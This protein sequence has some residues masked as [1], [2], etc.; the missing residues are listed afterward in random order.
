MSH[1]HHNLDPNIF[2]IGPFPVRWY[3]LF[4]VISFLIGYLLVKKNFKAKNIQLSGDDYDTLLFDLMLGVILGGRLG[5]ILFYN[6]AFYM[7]HPLS[8]FAVWEGGMSF[9][10]GA[11]GVIIAGL[12]FC[13]QHKITFYKLADPVMPLVAIGLGLGRIGNFINGEL[14][15]KETTVP[16]GMVFPNS[17]PLA[18]VRHPSQIYEALLEGLVLFLVCQF[19]HRKNH[20][21]GIVFWTFIGLYGI[22]RF[23]LEFLR[24]PDHIDLYKNGL[25]LGYFS[26]GQFLSLF[27]ILTSLIFII[28]IMFFGNKNEIRS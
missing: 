12:I 18:L 1:Y 22:F 28:K 6:L 8:V 26:M 19:I 2:T 4:Y 13:K 23:F 25:I 27:M 3:G 10:G 24:E 20:K 17:D 15:G 7:T 21:S 9:H 11:L 14:Y 5:Y 16:W